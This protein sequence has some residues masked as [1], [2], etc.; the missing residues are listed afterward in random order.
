MVNATST[1]RSAPPAADAE[2]PFA[3]AIHDINGE[4]PVPPAGMVE[5]LVGEALA[6]SSP[7]SAPAP[8]QNGGV[9]SEIRGRYCKEHSSAVKDLLGV[10]R[11]W[12][13]RIESF[14]QKKWAEGDTLMHVQEQTRISLGV[15]EEALRKWR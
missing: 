7:V 4:A 8:A 9:A 13:E 15:V 1:S 14:L 3:P 2:S 10:A 6:E 12:E 11:H 5:S